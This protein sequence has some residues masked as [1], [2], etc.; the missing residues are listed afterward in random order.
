M[1][2]V[3]SHFD[4]NIGL[5]FIFPFFGLASGLFF[6]IWIFSI[7]DVLISK[8]RS[9]EKLLWILIIVVLN[10]AGAVLYLIVVKGMDKKIIKSN[11]KSTKRL[12]RSKKNR[13][14]AGICGGLGE[15]FDIDPVIIRLIWVFVVLA[16]GSGALAYIIAWIIIPEKPGGKKKRRKSN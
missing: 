12:Y 16:G 15:Y 1:N 7:I 14:I 8:K 4:D 10:I 2:F 13:V 11:K 9:D 6:V 3:F 5:P